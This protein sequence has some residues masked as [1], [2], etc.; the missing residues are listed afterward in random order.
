MVCMILVRKANRFMLYLFSFLEI[1]MDCIKVSTDTPTFIFKDRWAEKIVL[2]TS[3]SG[4]GVYGVDPSN[5]K[6]L[7][8]IWKIFSAS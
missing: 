1:S 5:K 6:T 3:I 8:S 4:P 7:S 2:I